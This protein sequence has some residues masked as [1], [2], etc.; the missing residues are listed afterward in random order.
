MLK[1]LRKYLLWFFVLV[2]VS[3]AIGFIF[4]PSFFH[5]FTSIT[6]LFTCLIFLIHQPLHKGEYL[7]S[8]LSLICIGYVSEVIGVKTGLVFGKYHYGDGLGYKLFSV[9][10]VVSL[11]W[12][13]LINAGKLLSTHFTENRLLSALLSSGII[14]A[15]DLLIEPVA[16]SLDFWY[17]ENGKA[18]L[19]N[20]V[21]WFLVAF[22]A[23]WVLHKQ[24]INGDKRI[25]AIILGLQIFFFGIINLN[26]L[27]LNG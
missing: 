7:M 1:D 23:S 19:H 17:F 21:G 3:G 6:L 24:L 10:I 11:N 27:F 22:I 18:A 14:T 5:P 13:F 16:G 20:S 26:R 9:P 4:K 8:F 12:A 15:I 25:S 2:Y